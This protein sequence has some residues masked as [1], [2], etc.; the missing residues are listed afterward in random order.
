MIKEI[1]Q[2]ADQLKKGISNWR[3]R[4]FP[5]TEHVEIEKE[6]EIS[7]EIQEERSFSHKMVIFWGVGLTFVFIGYL[8][9][10]TLDYLYLLLAAYIISLAME[11]I[12]GFFSRLT[13]HR[14][15]GI[16]ISYLI[17]FLFLLSGFLIIFPFLM[18]WGTEIFN[19]IIGN[20]Q[21][22]QVAI[23]TE[24]LEAYLQSISRL[25]EFAANE[26][27]NYIETTDANS[28]IAA[29]SNNLG[30]IMNISSSYLKL[31]SGYAMNI[32]G[33]L[34]AGMGKI[35]I[36]LTMSIFFSISHLDVKKN[37]KYLFR[38]K[39]NSA[40]KIE[41]V[42]GGVA[43]R[44]KAQILLCFVIGIATFIGLWILDWI[45]FDL[46]QK[47][48][49]ALLAGI[50][51]ILPYLGPWLGA[52]P[53]AISALVLFGLPGMI[54]VIILYTIIQQCEEK[55][56]VPLVMNKTLGVSPLLVLV[57]MLFGGLLMGFFGV[58]LAVPL[59]VICSIIFAVP[60]KK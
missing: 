35:L 36:L 3:N 41:E 4:S 56:F 18:S 45:G 49:L 37:L 42:Y 57:S 17:L 30:N 28:V 58:L 16:I 54:A 6:K 13:R 22:I 52:I 5:H 33:R 10:N 43:N 7:E 60:H 50:F 51:E 26:L 32:V 20:G 11:G 53:A 1:K 9:W 38:K 47:G 31:L 29:V 46:P 24:G 44:L 48:T 19:I 15:I 39:A 59:A 23:A 25:P 8:M 40:K 14:S 2:K 21:Q 12:I 34:F 27:L 55:F